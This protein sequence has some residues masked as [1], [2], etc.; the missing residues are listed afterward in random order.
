MTAITS[1]PSGWTGSSTVGQPPSARRPRN[2]WS[3]APAG[4]LVGGM[5][6]QFGQQIG[7]P[8]QRQPHL[9]EHAGPPPHLRQPDQL[10][11]PHRYLV[12]R[13]RAEAGPP[14]QRLVAD[15]RAGDRVPH[16]R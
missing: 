1:A 14:H 11:R 12:G 16:R 6:Q 9:E 7:L 3:S 2:P 8:D 13:E 4:L 15:R 10:A 5:G